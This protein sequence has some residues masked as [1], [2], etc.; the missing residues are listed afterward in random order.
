MLLRE[1]AYC[2]DLIVSPLHGLRAAASKQLWLN[3]DGEKLGIKPAGL[4]AHRVKV[5]V[6]ELLLNIDVFIQQ[7]LRSVDVHV[8]RYG[9]LVDGK[10]IR[11]FC[12]SGFF[13]FWIHVSL[14]TAGNKDRE[15]YSKNDSDRESFR[16]VFG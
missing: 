8:D 11:R 6:A 15:Q 9:P 5:A 10:G 7:S 13:G 12:H 16:A 1:H 2:R 4:R 14:R 3:P